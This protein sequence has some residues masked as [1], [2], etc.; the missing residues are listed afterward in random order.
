[1]QLGERWRRAKSTDAGKSE[2]CNLG[3]LRRIT[4]ATRTMTQVSL[5]GDS[6]RREMFESTIGITTARR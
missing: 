6:V 5:S 2:N 4:D 1:V 3:I